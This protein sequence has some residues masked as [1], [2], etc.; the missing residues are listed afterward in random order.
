MNIENIAIGVDIEDIERFENK[1][2]KFLSR[3]FSIGEI[4]YCKSKKNAAQ[5]FAA[6]Y[7]AKEAVF[8]ALSS[9]GLS[10]IEYNKIEVFHKDNV[11]CIRFLSEFENKFKAKLSLSHDRT[12]AVAYVIIE[13]S[14][15]T[16]DNK[17]INK[18]GEIL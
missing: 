9:F 17:N 11:P 16:T 2:D 10:G 6:R 14:E 18:K 15:E 12:K 4:E 3:V 7:C 13:K 8:K 1:D 5:H